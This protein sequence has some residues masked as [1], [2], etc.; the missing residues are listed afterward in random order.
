MIIY[1]N[2]KRIKSI[3]KATPFL[4]KLFYKKIDKHIHTKTFK[5]FY[6]GRTLVLV[7]TSIFSIGI[8][9][10]DVW[11]IIHITKLDNI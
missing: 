5:A 10:L 6:I 1:N 8:N 11:L 3:I 2:I 4:Y 9:I 7:A